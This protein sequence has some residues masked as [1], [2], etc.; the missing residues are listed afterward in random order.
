M[1]GLP[2]G[3]APALV[4]WSLGVVVFMLSVGGTDY[5]I[6]GLWT[7]RVW[8]RNV[9]W[10]AV[11]DVL[12]R[13]PPGECVEADNQIAPQL[14]PR[15][16]VTRVTS[17][18]TAPTKV[19]GSLGLATW[20]VLDLSPSR[21]D[22]GWQGDPPAVALSA[23]EQRGYAISWQEGPIVLLHKDQPVAPLCRGLY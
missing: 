17:A 6:N 14:T 1:R 19:A 18:P 4:A 3:L 5:P 9:R 2:L 20:I 23:A 8:G 15:D 11:H 16:Y 12:P 13:I 10:H 21:K 7:G 22:T